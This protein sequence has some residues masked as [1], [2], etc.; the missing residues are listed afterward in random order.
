MI[1][2]LHVEVHEYAMSEKDDFAGQKS[3]CVG[4]SAM[5]PH[6]GALQPQGEPEKDTER[7]LQTCSI[8]YDPCG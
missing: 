3:S 1:S 6:G 7:E 4:A 8:L 2:L 5:D